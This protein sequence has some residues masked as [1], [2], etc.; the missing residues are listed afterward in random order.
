MKV[1]IKERVVLPDAEIQ[2]WRNNDS[3]G[4]HKP[5]SL[6]SNTNNA[7]AGRRRLMSAPPILPVGGYV[8][9]GEVKNEK[10]LTDQQSGKVWIV[11]FD[12]VD[13][14][15]GRDR[16]VWSDWVRSDRRTDLK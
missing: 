9:F 2:L 12:Q 10:L 13:Q 6:K 14:I 11:S 1:S 15:Y 8:M 5:L 4:N 16:V 7:P 3:V